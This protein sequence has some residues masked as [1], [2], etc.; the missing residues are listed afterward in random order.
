[1]PPPA[2]AA[3][4][5]RRRAEAL[6]REGRGY[7]AIARRLGVDRDRVRQLLGRGRCPECGGPMEYRANRCRS[8]DLERHRAQAE[9]PGLA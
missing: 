8:C 1:M 3:A 7:K 5:L 2:D 4:R 9:G 6:R